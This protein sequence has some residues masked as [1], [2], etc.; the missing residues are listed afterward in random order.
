LYSAFT[1]QGFEDW[2]VKF[3]FV[4]RLLLEMLCHYIHLPF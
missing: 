4:V 1:K 2:F 3:A